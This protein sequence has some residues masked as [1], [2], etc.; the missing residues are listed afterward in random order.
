MWAD[1]IGDSSWSWNSIFPFYKKSPHFTPPNTKKLGPGVHWPYD[2][3]AFSP[4]GG[5]L[6]VSFSNYEQ[7]ANIHWQKGM[8]AAG[9]KAQNGLNSGILDGYATTSLTEDP[10]TETRSSSEASFLRNALK[11]TSLK[12]YEY[13]MGK[14]I[15]FSSSKKATGVIV[16]T[17]GTTYTLSARK[18]II[19]SSGAVSLDTAKGLSPTNSYGC[20]VPITAASHGIWYR[21]CRPAELTQYPCRICA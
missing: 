9:L 21:T 10:R 19:I 16:E 2:S 5:P 18:E 1:L 15:L 7:P 8:D 6:Q 17:N 4:R 20:I 12:F 3:S 14:R 13:T 11:T